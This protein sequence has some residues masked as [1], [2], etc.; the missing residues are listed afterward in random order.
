M[1]ESQLHKAL[2]AGTVAPSFSL[3]ATPDQMVS[4]DDLRGAPVILAFYP[5]DWSPVCGDQMALYNEALAEF[6]RSKAQLLGISVDGVWC[7]AAFTADRSLHFPLLADFEPKG[8]VARRYGVYRDKEGISDRALFVIDSAG[9]IRWSYVS[10]LG[11]NPGADGIL[12]A[13]D[14]IGADARTAEVQ[15]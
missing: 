9:I 6:Q 10:P 8:E 14:E 15:S 5:A 2:V 11:I 4:L 3:P 13:L 1:S 7:H 12:Q